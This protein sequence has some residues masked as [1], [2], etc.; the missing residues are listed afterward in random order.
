MAKNTKVRRT[1]PRGTVER[2]PFVLGMKRISRS[3]SSRR[4]QSHF[5]WMVA[6]RRQTTFS[7][8]NRESI[9]NVWLATRG[10]IVWSTL[11]SLS[12]SFGLVRLFFAISIPE[13][14]RSVCLIVGNERHISWSQ[15]RR[16]CVPWSTHLLQSKSAMAKKFVS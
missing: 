15:A 1:R 3:K 13:A 4:K 11:A 14:R 16:R 12:L 7:L 10:L 5:L 6:N 8:T 2:R 9:T